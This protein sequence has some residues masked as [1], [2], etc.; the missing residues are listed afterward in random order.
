M[1]RHVVN[2]YEGSDHMI[3]INTTSKMDQPNLRTL[4][5]E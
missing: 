2:D 1:P 4:S 3:M 5:Q